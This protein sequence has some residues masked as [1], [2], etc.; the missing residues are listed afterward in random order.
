MRACSAV[1]KQPPGVPDGHEYGESGAQQDVNGPYVGELMWFTCEH[2]YHIFALIKSTHPLMG[3]I[4]A[5]VFAHP[6]AVL[7]SKPQQLFLPQGMS[8]FDTQVFE[9]VPSV[10]L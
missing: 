2:W 9:P 1:W 10:Q 5:G 4:V 3:G 6:T 7:V 8:W